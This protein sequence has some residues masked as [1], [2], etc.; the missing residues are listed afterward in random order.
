MNQKCVR[1][2]GVGLPR[3]YSGEV[4]S[5]ARALEVVGQRWT[6]LI[7]RD[8]FY[9]VGR[10]SDFASHLKIPKAVLADRLGSLVRDG[11]LERAC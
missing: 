9:G 3:E 7:I 1:M 10:F 4:C 5:L 6:L 11:V 8:A 2:A